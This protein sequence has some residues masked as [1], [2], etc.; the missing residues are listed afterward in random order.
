MSVIRQIRAPITPPIADAVAALPWEA[1]G[2][3]SAWN[4]ASAA[5][6]LEGWDVNARPPFG[7]NPSSWRGARG[8]VATFSGSAVTY[9]Q[10]AI[11]DDQGRSHPGV[12]F[13]ASMMTCPIGA[14][15]SGRTKVGVC[16]GFLSSIAA[17]SVL[18]EYGTP[19]FVSGNGRFACAC[20]NVGA[21]DFTA[22]ARGGGATGQWLSPL[23]TIPVDPCSLTWIFDFNDTNGSSSR[24]LDNVEIYGGTQ[25][26]TIVAGS[27]VANQNLYFGARDGVALPAV[28]TLSQLWFFDPVDEA[29]ISRYAR[30]CSEA[31]GETA[32]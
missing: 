3:S 21:G 22:G 17:T 16:V 5:S 11:T 20:H 15:L 8:T 13:P 9:S 18:F 30:Y 19:D 7:A 29:T 2:A 31:V 24:R 1:G 6:T 12:Y 14:L 25:L 26:S 28:V 32:A 27:T 4:P 10:T 23:N